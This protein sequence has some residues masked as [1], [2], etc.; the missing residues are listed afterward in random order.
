MKERI[1]RKSYK[2]I[3]LPYNKIPKIANVVDR[4]ESMLEEL[5]LLRNPKYKFI[6]EYQSDLDKFIQGYL[7]GRKLDTMGQWFYYPWNNTVVHL[8]DEPEHYELRTARNKNLITL[9][10]QNKFYNS[11]IGCVGMSVGSGVAL[12]IVLTGG[13]K[14]IKLADNDLLGGSNLNRIKQ[15]YTKLGINKAI[16][17]AREIFELNPYAQVEVFESGLTQ[18][19][20]KDFFEG[21]NLLIEEADSPFFKLAAR[22]E[23]KKNK[24]PVLMGTD[25]GDGVIV[26]VERYDLNEKLP[27][28]HGLF[29][30]LQPEDFIKMNP[31][32][33]PKL[34]ARI[35]GAKFN[36]P[37]MLESV[38]EVGKS[39]YSWPQ[40]GTAAQI[41]GGI[42]AML[43]RKILV[44]EKVKTGRYDMNIAEN[45]VPLSKKEV[46][47][48]KKYLKL[49]G[50]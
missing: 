35:S 33:F 34:A 24:I 27:L 39:L 37:R 14:R 41:C 31:K 43:A 50:E 44:G 5:F 46:L 13:A 40:L 26:D 21:L 15:S 10:E 22:Q 29:G 23:A 18:E 49:L 16:L 12:T 25:N 17:V 20:M 32:D 30:K 1:D 48:R 4:Y 3:N 8:L 28:L 47:L 6:K 2:P 45:F 36:T 9:V 42:L 38:F 19:N 7:K 11:T